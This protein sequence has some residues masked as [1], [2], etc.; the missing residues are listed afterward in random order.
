MR[1]ALTSINR[2]Y[3]V[4]RKTDKKQFAVKVFD[5]NVI[6]QNEE[7]IKCLLYELKMMRETNFYRVL[8]LIELYEGEDHLYALCELYQGQ[9]LLNAIIKKGSQP[10]EK[11]LTILLQ[12]LEAL[13]YLHGK[14]IMHRDIKP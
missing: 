4:E 6:M 5:K 1:R 7:E 12:L 3:L 13:S 9:N 14:Q 10:E 2:I 8:R 11:G